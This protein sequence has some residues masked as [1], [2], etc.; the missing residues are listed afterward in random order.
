MQRQGALTTLAGALA[1]GSAA[2]M[3]VYLLQGWLT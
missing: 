2:A 3:A 1:V